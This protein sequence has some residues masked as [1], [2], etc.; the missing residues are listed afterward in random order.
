MGGR[1]RP[2]PLVLC[3][4]VLLASGALTSCSEDNWTYLGLRQVWV[5]TIEAPD[6]LQTADTLTVA[7]EGDGWCDRPEFSHVETVRDS[8]RVAFTVWAECYDWSGSG[9]MPPTYTR[10]D[11]EPQVPPPFNPGELLLVAY[12][13]DSSTVNDTVQVVP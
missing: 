9:P 12:R 4:V 2:T 10:V 6:T 5:D 11:C 1:S 7:L 8:C 3:L 13:P